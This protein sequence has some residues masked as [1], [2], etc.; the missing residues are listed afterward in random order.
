MGL[1]S[2]PATNAA[3]ANAGVRAGEMVMELLRGD[4]TPSKIINQSRH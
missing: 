2:V 4:V 3:K 1:S